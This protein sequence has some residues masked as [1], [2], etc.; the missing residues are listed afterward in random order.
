MS[1]ER[2]VP[3]GT[4]R[5]I[6]P[7]GRGRRDEYPTEQL[8]RGRNV[9]GA[10]NY[11]EKYPYRETHGVKELRGSKEKEV[12]NLRSDSKGTKHKK[13]RKKKKDETDPVSNPESCRDAKKAVETVG[14]DSKGAALFLPPSRDDATP[15]RDEPM[16]GESVAYKS[17]S[18]KDR[19]EKSKSN[20]MEKV[21]RKAESSM[22]KKESSGKSAKATQEKPPEKERDKS[23]HS[24]LSIKKNREECPAKVEC[25]K[26]QPL[27]KSEKF[28]LPRKL[29]LK[30][31]REYKETKPAKEEKQRKDYPREETKHEKHDKA[32]NRDEKLK[33]TV[34]ADEK[35]R[36]PEA[37]AD[38]RK[39]KSDEKVADREL[40]TP[41][42]KSSKVEIS[43]AAKP[44]AKPKTTSGTEKA[45]RDF[46]ESSFE[47]ET[48][49]PANL[50]VRK[51][52]INRE[53]GKKIV[54]GESP[55]APEEAPELSE[56]N[57]GKSKSDKVKTKARRKVAG[58]EMTG[59]VL[60]DYTRLAC[61]MVFFFLSC[62]HLL[63]SCNLFLGS[64]VGQ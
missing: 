25:V 19:K 40:G 55:A 7:H 15:V 13:H 51:I 22:P 21:K 5:D 16:E 29:Q 57:G 46:V 58:N 9:G 28:F 6:S 11:P 49:T 59:S 12:T 48:V 3:P 39:R 45:A 33:R 53:S 10:C 20:K 27:P 41:P 32:V 47:N 37:K 8:P 1:P 17:M 64:L 24:E 63:I 23:P 26:V 31:G 54:S 50:P 38:K 61:F 62:W 43:E 36:Q 30:L 56:V 18:D 14:D 44:S 42:T 52:K 60:V 34:K 2:F 4:R 35:P